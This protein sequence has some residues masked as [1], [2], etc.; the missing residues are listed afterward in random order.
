MTTNRGLRSALDRT[1]NCNFSKMP[2]FGSRMVCETANVKHIQVT[3][4]ELYR[5]TEIVMRSL[6]KHR[7][8]MERREARLAE[9]AKEKAARKEKL[10][11]ARE[12]IKRHRRKGSFDSLP[13]SLET[14]Q[15]HDASAN[16]NRRS[17][18]STTS[19]FNVSDKDHLVRE[20]QDSICGNCVLQ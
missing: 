12:R 7:E 8:E 4:L 18:T 11:E 6:Q 1:P 2:V 3:P 19:T 5:E 14:P 16:S 17:S 13:Q 15:V 10:R 20:D 9:W